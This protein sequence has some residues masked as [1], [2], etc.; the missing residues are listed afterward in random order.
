MSGELTPKFGY[1]STSLRKEF[2]VFRKTRSRAVPEE[3]RC[4]WDGFAE[5]GRV[6]MEVL[7]LMCGN[8]ALQHMDGDPMAIVQEEDLTHTSF[9]E[10]FRYDCGGERL[11]GDAE[12]KLRVAC[13]EHRDTGVLTV[14]PAPRGET[15]GFEGFDR[16]ENQWRGMEIAEGQAIVFAGE[17]FPLVTGLDLAALTHRVVLPIAPHKARWSMPF[18]LLPA[19]SMAVAEEVSRLGKGLV[20]ANY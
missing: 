8:V 14:I 6:S 15:A 12:A 1:R 20:S 3:L 5:I 19:P 13:A 18:E 11:E 4:V 10:L 16:E 9:W 17:L 2:F 7:R